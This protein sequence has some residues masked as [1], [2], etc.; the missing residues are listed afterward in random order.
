MQVAVISGVTGQTGSYLA[1]TLLDKG[2]FVIGFSRRVS[3]DTSERIRHLLPN[4]NFQFEEGDIC[5]PHYI[6]SLL[7]KY[8][9]AEFY[10]LA[11][12]SHVATSFKQP[13]ITSDINYGGVL[14][15]LNC[16]KELSPTTKF[17]QASTSE[18]FGSSYD[19]GS[20]IKGKSVKKMRD[21]LGTTIKD[22]NLT[23]TYTE[24][25]N[26]TIQDF[27]DERK[28]KEPVVKEKYQDENTKMVPQSPYAVAKLG[29]H[30]LV[31]LYRESYGIYAA[32]GILFNHETL[33]YGT[34]LIIK[35]DNNLIDILPIGD[36]AR[37]KTGV[38]FNMNRMEYQEGK[39]VSNIKVWDQSGWTN[40]KW[41]SGYP[42][43]G[44][45]NPRIV[46]SRN[47]VYT[48]TG[49]HPCIMEDSKE[50]NTEDLEVED[51]VKLIDYPETVVNKEVSLEEAEILGMLAGDGNLKLNTPRFTNKDQS[52][53]ERFVKLWM[54]F[55]E[56]GKCNFKSSKS[57]FTGEEIGQVEAFGLHDYDYDLYTED[58]SPFGHK[59]KKVP[60][61]I[62]NSSVDCMEAFLIGY[63]AC[64][65]LKSNPCTYTFKNFKTNSATL[66]AGLLF[67]VSKVTGQ[68]Y[69]IT[70][71]E[72]N[73]WGKQQ[74][75]YSI[76][77]LSDK[78]DSTSK[79]HKVKELLDSKVSQRQ[80]HRETEISRSFIRK[81][82]NG[83]VPSNTHHLEK[84]NNEIKKII[85][86]PNYEGWF[87]DL[88]TESGTFAAGVGQG[89]VHNSPRRG[90]KFVTKKITKWIGQF[91]TWKGKV[92]NIDGFNDDYIC[93]PRQIDVEHTF[94]KLRLG[95]L[96][97]SRDWGHAKDYA[98][99]MYTILQQDK[100]DDFVLCTGE[101]RT[102]REFLTVAFNHIGIEDWEPFVVIDPEFYRPA[103][104]DYL[105]G[106]CKKAQ[107][108]FGWA[109]S[110]SFEGLVKEMVE[111]DS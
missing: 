92:G 91:N 45:K 78:E 41:V 42:H 83:Y 57:G 46:N 11:A 10:N 82:F 105:R 56:N 54:T 97:A 73:K 106:S 89:V 77:L 103:E 85:D 8:R 31:R 23:I 44:D 9:V 19:I 88:E 59:N 110:Y 47:S 38:I 49:S 25:L 67:L 100:P 96:D 28:N 107:E 14:N 13:V 98:E 61:Q 29:A 72:S 34:P 101:T 3:V 30:N 65:G 51:K 99:G 90:D 84:C 71:E 37:F 43:E 76:N 81:V 17:Y 53:K 1:E 109:P 15:I 5:D 16:I 50:K 48:A 102:I 63:N 62:L 32:A 79:Y 24:N 40:V 70:L 52:I 86:I 20:V 93:G 69:N 55:V 58:I 2:Y 21:V 75:Y 39:S 104:V 27:L 108:T 111:Y 68:K 87:F 4:A 60:I 26:F 35:D 18:L 80:I 33:S 12:Q 95:N 22:G 74:F 64:D 36:I 6:T 7:T 66:A 94:P